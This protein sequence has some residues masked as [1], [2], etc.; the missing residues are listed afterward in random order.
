MNEDNAKT[1]TTQQEASVSLQRKVPEVVANLQPRELR[2]LERIVLLLDSEGPLALEEIARRLKEKH[3]LILSLLEKVA[4][5]GYIHRQQD[6]CFLLDSEEERTLGS[7]VSGEAPSSEVRIERA[8]AL[9]DIRSLLV[10]AKNLDLTVSNGLEA[11]HD[12]SLVLRLRLEDSRIPVVE[13]WESPSSEGPP[14][15]EA[16][17]SRVVRVVDGACAQ[18]ALGLLKERLSLLSQC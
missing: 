12:D 7:T 13:L 1:R 14:Q 17:I 4:N 3:I 10:S 18:Q 11:R 16:R 9:L 5:A 2:L 6:G 8:I 15:T